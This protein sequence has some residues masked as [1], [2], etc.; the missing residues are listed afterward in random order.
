MKKLL[1]VILLIH[2]A[3][4]AFADD[5]AGIQAKQYKLQLSLIAKIY[6]DT[7]K[8]FSYETG[9]STWLSLC[10][11]DELSKATTPD[12]LAL[13]KFIKTK[14]D[15]QYMLGR[16]LSDMEILRAALAIRSMYIGYTIGLKEATHNHYE[17]LLKADKDASIKA[18]INAAYKILE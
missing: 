4:P 11:Q 17:D 13:E 7:H 6:D 10:G 5:Y 1:I 16:A 2:L 12:D 3:L 9:V 18:A 14:L 15:N 8:K